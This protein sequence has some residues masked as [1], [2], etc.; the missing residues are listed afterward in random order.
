MVQLWCWIYIWGLI[1][2]GLRML[3]LKVKY[4]IKG[5]K[6]FQKSSLTVLVQ[7]RF[8]IALESLLLEPW[9]GLEIQFSEL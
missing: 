8:K 4:F 5:P 9:T 3:S 1:F 2:Q 7:F 6:I